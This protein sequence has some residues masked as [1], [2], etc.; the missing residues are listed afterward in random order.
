MPGQSGKLGK[1]AAWLTLESQKHV[2]QAVEWPAVTLE[3]ASL[4]RH[5]TR[6]LVPNRWKLA[7]RVPMPD[8]CARW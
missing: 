6:G 1:R 2:N 4:E 7:G 3:P 8:G 5:M